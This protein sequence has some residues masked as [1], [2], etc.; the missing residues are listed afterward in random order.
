MF[1]I[2]HCL[3][4]YLAMC[5]SAMCVC[6]YMLQILYIHCTNTYVRPTEILKIYLIEIVLID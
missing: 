6:I 4:G 2:F 3:P 1:P 5:G